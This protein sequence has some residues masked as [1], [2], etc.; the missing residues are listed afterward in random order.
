[1]TQ[2]E[3]ILNQV[4]AFIL[5]T[6]EAGNDEAKKKAIAEELRQF[7]DSLTPEEKALIQDQVKTHNG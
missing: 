3:T 4:E 2:K 6:R 5:R 1:M 7:M